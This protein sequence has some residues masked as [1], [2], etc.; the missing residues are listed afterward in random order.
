MKMRVSRSA[1]VIT[2][3][4]SVA[5]YA[6][7]QLPG[8]PPVSVKPGIKYI[9]TVQTS[10]GTFYME[11]Y[12]EKA[13]K[14][15]SNFIYLAENGFFDGLTFHRVVGGHII[16]G[17]C[18]RGDGYGDPGY[19]IGFEKTPYK[20][21]EGAVGMARFR[22]DYDSASSQFYICLAPRPQLDGKY[23]VFAKVYAGMDVVHKI[24]K[25]RTDANE[26]PLK[27]I[28]THRVIITE[29]PSDEGG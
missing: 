17:G 22:G 14:T 21:V 25:V 7:K 23:C 3:F 11:L 13:P 8:P 12:A 19:T 29:M 18:P 9:A 4:F 20:H 5:A 26:K 10:S 2:L 27:P 6:A 15:V 28:Y 16:Q 24:G 1:L